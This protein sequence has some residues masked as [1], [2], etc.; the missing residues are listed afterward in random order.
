[1]DSFVDKLAQRFNAGELIKANGEAEALEADRLK[2][3]AEEYDKM[4]KEIRRLNL[5]TVELSEQVSQLIQCGIEQIEAYEAAAKE[6]GGEDVVKEEQLLKELISDGIEK[7]KESFL[8][9]ASNQQDMLIESVENQQEIMNTFA[10]N[11][12][13]MQQESMKRLED[14]LTTL[15]AAIEESLA[16]M[17]TSLRI[18]MKDYEPMLQA[19]HNDN[20]ANKAAVDENMN[21]MKEMIVKVRLLMDEQSKQLLDFVHKEN[22]KVY[23]N[24]QAVVNDQTSLRT[25]ELAGQL[26]RVEKKA[27]RPSLLLVCTFLLAAG[28][29]ALQVLRILGIL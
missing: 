7:Q 18:G 10:A 13:Q 23:R 16:D 20:L 2:A 26:E 8:K 22:V 14:R 6:S 29:L 15:R 28:S 21:Q 4:M 19:M 25:K 17:E 9:I 11:S 24:V 5:K 1:M 12:L 3:Q 27:G